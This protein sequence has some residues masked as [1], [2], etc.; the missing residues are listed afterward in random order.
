MHEASLLLAVRAC[1]HIHLISKNPTNKTTAKAAVTQ[2]LSVVNQRMELSDARLEYASSATATPPFSPSTSTSDLA[3]D[4]LSIA[5]PGTSNHSTVHLLSTIVE[6]VSEGPET[7]E[8]N[9]VEQS[10]ENHVDKVSTES[11]S[12]VSPPNESI[13]NSYVHVVATD[14]P[15]GTSSSAETKNHVEVPTTSQ[16]ENEESVLKE[17]TETTTATLKDSIDTKENISLAVTAERQGDERPKDSAVSAKESSLI[18]FPSVFH[19]DSYLLFRALCKLS[20]KGLNED[21]TGI[22]ND[23]IALQNKIL[24]LELLLDILTNSGPAFRNGEKFI[25]AIRSYLCVSL[26][27]NC[28]SQVAQVVGLSLQIFVNLVQNFK[29]HLKSELEVF[30]ST[31]FLRI[32]ESENS[33]YD[34]KYRVVEVFQIICKDPSS[35][36]ELFINYDCDLEA[37]NLFSSI[38]D[39]FAKIAKNPSLSFANRGSVEFMS[40]TT[41]KYQQEEQ[42]LRTMGNKT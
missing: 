1:F 22:E 26:L 15:V 7:Q 14:V 39:G 41:K 35:Q 21:S 19:K 29:E 9:A 27:N 17:P 2:M 30:I 36:I 31:I 28:T 23:P 33:T 34:H 6:E 16:P 24:S 8:S 3:T 25:F 5:I 4:K 37:I 12:I 10:E 13:D 32:L 20:M 38:V 11:S 18:T 42:H 40:S